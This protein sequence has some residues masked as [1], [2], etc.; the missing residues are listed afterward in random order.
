MVD[1]EPVLQAVRAARVLGEVAPDRADLLAR[2]IG[3]VEVAL[4][5][6]GPCDV[7]V[8]HARLDDDPLALDVDLE[9]PVHPRDRDDDAV[10]DRQR[11]TREPG[12]G[13]ARDER[14]AVPRAQPENRLHVSRRAGSTTA[15][16]CARQPVRPS[17]S[18]VA[19]WSGSVRTNAS[20]SAA[21]RSS[22]KPVGRHTARSYSR[23]ARCNS[24]SIDH[25]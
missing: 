12:A 11:A 2:R 10:R 13:S 9:D 19:S 7:E 23:R 17:Q 6:H 5:R 24:N 1:R 4:R 14:D 20:P 15:A 18:Y 3:R 16:G 21:R 8:R 25:R 22:T